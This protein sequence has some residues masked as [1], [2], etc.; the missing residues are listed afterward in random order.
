M[1][2]KRLSPVPSKTPEKC[3]LQQWAAL[4]L[5]RENQAATKPMR[6]RIFWTVNLLK[7]LEW[8]S[9]PARQLLLADFI[10]FSKH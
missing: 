4:F 7:Y 6:N 10:L 9:L 8:Q 3:G 5:F 1:K 2:F